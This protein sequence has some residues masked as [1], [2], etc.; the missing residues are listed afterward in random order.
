MNL[1]NVGEILLTQ[2]VFLIR[3]A[4]SEIKEYIYGFFSIMLNS[5][6][7]RV[8]CKHFAGRIQEIEE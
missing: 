3:G 4:K 1:R 6:V 7:I 2:S 5:F 8:E